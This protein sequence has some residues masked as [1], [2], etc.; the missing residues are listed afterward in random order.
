MK[1]ALESIGIKGILF[2]EDE[3]EENEIIDYSEQGNL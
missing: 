3:I 1:I 2:N